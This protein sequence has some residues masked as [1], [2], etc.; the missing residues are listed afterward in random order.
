MAGV[1]MDAGEALTLD[2]G[3]LEEPASGICPKCGEPQGFLDAVE[4]SVLGGAGIRRCSRCGVRATTDRSPHQLLFTCEACGLPFL[5]DNGSAEPRQCSTCRGSESP[6]DPPESQIVHAME[7][8]VRSALDGSWK[9]VTSGELSGYLDEVARQLTVRIDGAPESS[10]VVLIE[11]DA[12]RAT[13]LPSGVVLI[14]LGLLRFLEDEA[15]LAFVLARELAHVAS[16]EAAVRLVRWSLGALAQDEDGRPDAAWTDAMLDL[17]RLGYGRRRELDADATALRAMLSLRY[18]PSSAVRYL[19]RLKF[20]ISTADSTVA[21]AAVA[22]PPPGYRVRKLERILYGRI[23]RAPVQRV[24]REVF[25]R[26]AATAL[27]DGLVATTLGSVT[28]ATVAKADSGWGLS[29]RTGI[30]LGALAVATLLLVLALA[31]G[32]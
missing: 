17:T 21:D 11:E 14:S 19:R 22:Y 29:R 28:P 26:A 13:A 2:P 12:L 23:G 31:L 5:A 1:A 20:A 30:L 3:S 6:V 8:E 24:N 10:R 15:E 18:D 25:R 32:N 4:A 27:G 9:F 16:G 7:T